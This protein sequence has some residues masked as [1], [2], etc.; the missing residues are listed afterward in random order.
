MSTFIDI[1][2]ITSQNFLIMKKLL[3]LFLVLPLIFSSCKKEEENNTPTPVL[4]CTD[5]QAVNYESDATQ[6]DCTCLYD[7]TGVWETTSAILNGQDVLNSIEL[8]FL[9]A[10]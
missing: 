9:F 3:Y 2:V 7:V 5:P 8:H 1:F 6:D 4:G 10:D